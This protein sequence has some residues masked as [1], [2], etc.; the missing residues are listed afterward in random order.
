VQG[1][2]ELDLADGSNLRIAYRWGAGDVERMR[3]H[4]AELVALRPEAIMVG[5]TPALA[6]AAR[7]T[8]SVPIIFAN[9]ADPISQGFVSSLARP[10]G[11][12]TG[13]TSLEFSM[14]GKWIE[15]LKEISPSRARANIIFNPPTA[16]YFDSFMRS[17]EAASSSLAV[18]LVVIP[19]ANPGE[20]ERAIAASESETNVGLVVVPSV[21]VTIHRE[22][23]IAQAARYRLPAIYGFSYYAASGG[24][25]AYGIDV[26]DMYARA[27]RYVARVLKG[28][29]PG[30]LPI[31]APTKFQLV[32]NLKTAKA[33]DLTVPDTLLARADEVIE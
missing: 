10:G 30:D 18:K 12:I 16:P 20:I 15:A 17:M 4:A 29:K 33:L 31:Q 13:F 9:V 14:G 24:L 19:V 27:A 6:A 2:K 25:I 22:F 11:S 3:S 8:R 26:R 28:E 5:S 23:I 7:E 32:I 1:L 21:F